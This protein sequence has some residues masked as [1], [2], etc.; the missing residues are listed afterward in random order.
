MLQYINRRTVLQTTG[1]LLGGATMLIGPGA[2]QEDGLQ[3]TVRRERLD[4]ERDD[5]F[6]VDVTVPRGTF[7][8]MDVSFRRDT[9]IGPRRTFVVNED[10]SVQ[11]DPEREEDVANPVRARS[12]AGHD[13]HW[14]LH[15]DNEDIGYPEPDQWDG[16][17]GL[18][19]FLEKNDVV[20][21]DSWDTDSVRIPP[22]GRDN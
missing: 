5:V 1:G 22:R 14:I 4:P 9:Y 21:G 10:G 6:A 7:E 19:V 13:G 8:G 11:I 15:F 20:P 17:L 18:G 12:V 16:T 3:M 2:A